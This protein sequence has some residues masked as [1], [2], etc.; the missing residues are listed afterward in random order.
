M[1]TIGTVTDI[2]C[3]GDKLGHGFCLYDDEDVGRLW[4]A[5]ATIE[6]AEEMRRK[7]QILISSAIMVV[8]CGA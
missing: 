4:I 8:E 5:Y 3:G 7:M 6:E 1:A 2:D